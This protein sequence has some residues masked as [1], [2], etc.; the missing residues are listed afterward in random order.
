MRPIF[1]GFCINWLG[2]WPLH[3]ISSCSDFGF[4]FAE[5]FV[6]EKRLPDSA[7]REYGE[8]GG[9][10]SKFFN[11]S[12]IYSFKR[13]NQPYK[14]PIWQFVDS[15]TRRV[16]ESFSITN[17]STNS[18]QNRKG[19][20]GSVRDPWVTDLCKNPRKS[21]SLQCSFNICYIYTSIYILYISGVCIRI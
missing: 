12:S 15:P 11:L 8:L 4:E 16:G 7:S 6:I 1:R 17:I 3:Y 18:N 10:Y 21:A 20:K 14:V 2:I 5:I 13:L 19:S 9:R